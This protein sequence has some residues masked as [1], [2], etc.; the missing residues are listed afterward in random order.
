MYIYYIYHIIY[1]YIYL[2]VC[3]YYIYNIIYIYIYIYKIYIYI[4]I[5]IYICIY[6]CTPLLHLASAALR[7]KAAERKLQ[8][9]GQTPLAQILEVGGPRTPRRFW[10]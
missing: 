7:R 1:I 6:V 3:I 10:V 2:C 5:Y 4:Y 9:L 8:G